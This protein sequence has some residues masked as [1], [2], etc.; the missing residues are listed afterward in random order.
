MSSYSNLLIVTD[1]NKSK[2]CQRGHKDSVRQWYFVFARVLE[3]M[4]T[5]FSRLV[6]CLHGCVLRSLGDI[7]Q[8]ETGLRIIVAG[9]Q[10]Q[11]LLKSRN[12][13]FGLIRAQIGTS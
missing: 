7:S 3:L 5:A 10:F 2:E 13:C 12:G 8:G 1:L 4:L 11:R 9:F 6:H